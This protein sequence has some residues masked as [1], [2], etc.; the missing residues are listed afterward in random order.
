MDL[1][2][3]LE[4]QLGRPQLDVERASRVMQ[5]ADA[6]TRVENACFSESLIAD[7]WETAS[8]LLKRR[9]ELM[10][11][12]WDG[13]HSKGCPRIVTDMAAAEVHYSKSFPGIA[14]RLQSIAE[15]LDA[16]QVLPK[17]ELR[18]CDDVSAWPA[19]WRLVLERMNVCPADAI[20]P[21]SRVDVA[22][23]AAGQ[24]VRGYKANPFDCD[25]SLR[26][27]KARSETAAVE[28]ISSILTEQFNASPEK[29]SRTVVYCEDDSLAV[30]LDASLK[31]RGVPT[32]GAST[33]TKAHP[34]LQVLPLALELCWDPVD[35]Q[36]LLD[37]LTLPVLPLPRRVASSLARAL[38]QE[39]GL[40]SAAWEQAFAEI[41]EESDRDADNPGKIAERLKDWFCSVRSPHGE[42]IATTIIAAQ[43]RKVAKWAI[44]RA[45]LIRA[46]ADLSASGEQ[47]SV[48]LGEAA[49]Q[50]SL[51]GELVELSGESITQPQLARLLDEVTVRGVESRPCIVAAGGPTR[52]RS[53]TQ[54]AE[55]YES[56]IWLG[57]T[58]GNTPVSCW[59]VK[60]LE[61][62]SKAGIEVDDGT[63][64][65]RSLRRAEANGLCLAEE[66]V[67]TVLLPASEEQRVHPLW[68][69]VEQKVLEHHKS[70]AWSPPAVEDLVASG[71]CDLLAPFVFACESVVVE[72]AQPR[73]PLWTIPSSLM[74]DRETVSASELED[75]LACPLKWTLRYQAGLRSSE[76]ASLPN[77]YQ[78]R[79]NFFHAL[80]ERIFAGDGALPEV[81]EA[82]RLAEEAF[83]ERLVLDAAPLSQLEKRVECQR[84]KR[85]LIRATRVFVET[86][87]RG[88]YSNVEIEVPIEGS[89]F[90][91]PLQGWIDCVA[92]AEDGREAVIDF[93]YG[94]RSKFYNM[95]RD[96]RSVQLA[97]YAFSRQ[98][99]S[100]VFPAVAYLVLS[101]GKFFTPSG[102]PVQGID[103]SEVLE[104]P[105][106]ENIWNEFSAA[107]ATAEEWLTT[108]EAVPARPLQN[109]G[110]W[111]PGADIVL[112]DS[113]SSDEAQGVCR[114]CEFSQICGQ[115][116]V[117]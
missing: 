27:V 74:S 30:R 19:S 96:G 18:L 86:L 40:G 64:T 5:Y 68:L 105:S 101:D 12:G 54:I 98:Q 61:D 85:E 109:V 88:G 46:D 62:F 17:H 76:I 50:A 2:E 42:P 113:L 69:A 92:S 49:R 90:G 23:H 83:D 114:Y 115:E 37:L 8:E 56:L 32:M 57:V 53:L 89:A 9:D 70:S 14:E 77:D 66:A 39:P 84:L 117:Q 43:C 55:P 71:Q 73:R 22:L 7:R 6:L 58:T 1:L 15:A 100:G 79:G 99:S 36:C 63:N 4:T 48:A 28:F 31:R 112:S 87:H 65:L 25:E 35:P 3:W 47:V 78:L 38:S 95:I 91:K 41:C 116:V 34:V 104:G 60:Q 59:S 29:V 13:V 26:V 110:D 21:R 80:L 11:C 67:L 24:V 75:R 102:S 16:G 111:P 94:G 107:I 108:D 20:T 103:T 97:T 52:I 72:A 44:G 51:F 106:I 82:V 81:E 45:A 10:L 93:K 33:Q